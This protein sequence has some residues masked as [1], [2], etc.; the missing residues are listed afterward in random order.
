MAEYDRELREWRED[1]PPPEKPNY[2][3]GFLMVIL[4]KIIVVVIFSLIRGT[5]YG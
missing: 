3:G 2:A 5:G 4:A 1:W